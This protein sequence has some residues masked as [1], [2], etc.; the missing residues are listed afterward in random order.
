MAAHPRMCQVMLPVVGD[1][2]YGEPQYRP[3]F[4]AAERGGLRIA[5]QHTTHARGP[6]GMGMTYMERHALIPVAVMPQLISLICNGV[7]DAF[8]KLRFI[9]LEGGFSWLPHVRWRLDREFRQG[10]IEAPWIRKLPSQ[11]IRE[12]LALA[13]QPT[14]DISAAQ[15]ESVVDLMGTDEILVFATD[16][17]HFDFDN[18]DAAIPAGLSAGLREKI[19]W[20]NAAAFYD[21]DIPPVALAAAE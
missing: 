8:P 5:F 17:P 21:L 1:I 20:K 4:A 3:I 16:Y 9:M 13:T 18:P 6:Y 12:R 11:H 15:W 19:L 14:E 10:R 7:F 2:A